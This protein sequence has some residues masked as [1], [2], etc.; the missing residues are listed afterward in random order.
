MD[1]CTNQGIRV[2]APRVAMY[3]AKI[4]SVGFIE[5]RTR[6]P[7]G[8]QVKRDQPNSD[9]KFGHWLPAVCFANP[10]APSIAVGFYNL[11]TSFPSFTMPIFSSVSSQK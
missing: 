8:R 5:G 7:V 9:Q 10:D 2:E 11:F 1:D 6:R 3:D 4:R